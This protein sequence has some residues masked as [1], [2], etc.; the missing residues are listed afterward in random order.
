MYPSL[1]HCSQDIDA[2]YRRPLDELGEFIDLLG[3]FMSY[4][5]GGAFQIDSSSACSRIPLLKRTAPW[6]MMALRQVVVW[7][8]STWTAIWDYVSIPTPSP[9]PPGTHGICELML[10]FS[11]LSS[12]GSRAHPKLWNY[13]WM[14]P[15]GLSRLDVW[16]GT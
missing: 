16:K 9:C 6:R 2:S 11:L 5:N 8:L 13:L 12:T 3:V 4:L 14:N 15:T 1:L 7:F 10:I